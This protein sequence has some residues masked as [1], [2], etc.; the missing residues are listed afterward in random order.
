MF[1]LCGAAL[2]L[3]LARNA[4]QAQSEPDTLSAFS[5]PSQLAVYFDLLTRLKVAVEK[6]RGDHAATYKAVAVRLFACSHAYLRLA[7]RADL[8]APVQ[9]R[10]SA[11]SEL[12]A[13]AAAGLYPDSLADLQQDYADSLTKSR[14]G[15]TPG[16]YSTRI[17][18]VLS[19]VNL[20][21]VYNA[22]LD[23]TEQSTAQ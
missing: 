1:R 13:H 19:D 23:L 8:D 6:T 10:Y 9:A 11:S 21:T 2:L 7:Q 12:Y 4:A 15:Q 5:S 14:A 16:A 18:D 20:E 22:V 17:C 3:L